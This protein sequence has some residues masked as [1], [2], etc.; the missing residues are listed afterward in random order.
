MKYDVTIGIVNYNNYEQIRETIRSILDQTQGVKFR[1]YVVD[2][3]S[4]DNSMDLIAAEFPSI[5]LIYSD[6]NL[7]YGAANNIAMRHADSDYHAI[8][9]PDILLK[10]DVL[11][12]MYDFMQGNP[13]VG[14]CIPSIYYMN[15]DPQYLPKRNPK[16]KYLV[17]NRLPLKS[18]DKHRIA[19]KMLDC[20]LS[21]VT[22][23]EFA[24]GC[25]MFARTE[26]LKEVGGFDERFFMYFEDADLTRRVRAHARTVCF[27]DAKVYHNYARTSA[28]NPRF[29]I[30][31]IVSMFKY[32]FKWRKAEQKSD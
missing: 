18:L 17:A 10:E 30:I 28:R 23:V 14:M 16:L 6:R 11:K 15:G 8:V 5:S 22:D 13:D 2:N 25:F 7:G 12:H 20:D 24:S 32:F 27:P 31:H 9:N 26:L 29:F 19:Y 3:A 4:N 21:Q 1:I